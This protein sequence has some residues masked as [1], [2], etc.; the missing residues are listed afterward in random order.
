MAF[1][2]S[3]PSFFSL[4]F[5]ATSI[6]LFSVPCL[7]RR[8]FSIPTSFKNTFGFSLF[9]SFEISSTFSFSSSFR[10]RSC[11]A[12]LY[13]IQ[14]SRSRYQR[15]FSEIIPSSFFLPSSS[16]IL[17]TS[18]SLSSLFPSEGSIDLSSDLKVSFTSSVSS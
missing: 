15:S 13:W 3:A 16:N 2:I 7:L 6:S 12:G 11:W 18:L 1:K 9:P 17:Q 5:L 10:I 8:G 4:A 14:R